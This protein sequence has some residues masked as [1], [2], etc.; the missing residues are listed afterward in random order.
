[1]DLQY[2]IQ[3]KKGVNNAAADALSRCDHQG[4]VQA[5]SECIPTW[6]QR[7]QEGYEDDDHAKQLLV[8]LA[9]T[10]GSHQNFE[11]QNGVLKYKGRV[12]VGNNKI[13]QNH[14]LVALHNSGL[15]GHSGVSATYARVKQLFAW[16]SLKQSVHDFVRQCQICQQAK[17]E[18]IKTPGLLQ[19]LPIPD[20]A[21]EIISLDFIEG[22][23]PSD[24]YNALLVVID[25]FTKYGHFIPIKHPFTALQ[26]A[27]VF[28]NNVYKLHGLPKTIISDRDRVFTSAIWQ[29]LFKMSDTKL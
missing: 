12:W 9:L 14:I 23:P 21:W 3:Y 8:E 10:P 11:L 27:Q 6:I 4:N 1:M 20:Q 26:I 16:P 18:R 7:L 28:M 29:Q 5:I 22:L 15:G 25:K 13:A 19:P 17:T 24:N 2:S